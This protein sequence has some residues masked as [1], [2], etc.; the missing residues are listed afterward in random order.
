MTKQAEETVHIKENTADS[1][2]PILLT[3]YEFFNK[4][5]KKR[6]HD[7]DFNTIMVKKKYIDP[8]FKPENTDSKKKTNNSKNQNELDEIKA[9]NKTAGSLNLK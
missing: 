1:S 6:Y 8:T 9:M 2:K 3:L 7:V 5:T 4:E